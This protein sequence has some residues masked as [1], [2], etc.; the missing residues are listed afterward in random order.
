MTV[1]STPSLNLL[2][3]RCQVGRVDLRSPDA[4]FIVVLGFAAT[5]RVNYSEP[6]GAFEIMESISVR[7]D[8]GCTPPTPRRRYPLGR[9]ERGTIGFDLCSPD[10]ASIAILGFAATARVNYNN[11][12]GAFEI[13]ESISVRADGGL[14]PRPPADDIRWAGFIVISRY[15]L[16]RIVGVRRPWECLRLRVNLGF[17][18]SLFWQHLAI[19]LIS[20]SAIQPPSH[21]WGSPQR[22]G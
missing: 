12:P 8:G 11:P 17:H 9:V 5:A 7:A 2:R 6:P 21:C 22:R 13:M 3:R 1:G 15:S 20:A 19:R 18:P 16:Y 14:H 10:A 4:A